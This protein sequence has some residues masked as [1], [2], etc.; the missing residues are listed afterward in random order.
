MDHRSQQSHHSGVGKADVD[1]LRSTL[2]AVTHREKERIEGLQAQLDI[3]R[4]ELRRFI[5]TFPKS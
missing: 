3:M 4:Q 5:F 2:A 1:D